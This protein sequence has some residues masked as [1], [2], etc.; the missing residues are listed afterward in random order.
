MRILW[1]PH[2]GWHVPQ[3]A[4]IFCRALS[5]RHEVHVTD[6]VADFYTWRDYL[7]LRYPRNFL[8]RR[9]REGNIIVHGIPRFSPALYVPF[10]RRMNAAVFAFIVR[11]IIQHYRVD[12]VVGTF[13]V[14]P[15]RAPR[16]VFDLFDDNVS[17]WLEY[18]P[19]K[20]YA[21]EIADTERAYLQSADAVVAASSVLAE[22]ARAVTD[23][24][25]HHIPNPVNL[26]SFTHA[27]SRTLREQWGVKGLV[28]GM[29]G[30]YDKTAE[31]NRVLDAAHILSA[32]PLTFV[33]AGRG[34]AIP[35]AKKDVARRGLRRVRF[36]DSVRLPKSAEII[37]AFDI[38]LCPYPKNPGSEACTPMRMLLY[39]AAGIPAVCTDLKEV[40]RMAFPNVVLV[41]DNPESLARGILQAR[42][43][44]RERPDQIA[45][46]DLAHLVEE[47]ERV[48]SG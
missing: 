20:S 7:H 44:P 5:E 45:R 31:L 1:I 2:V 8:Y 38:G 18:G 19:V 24:P 10:L 13:V 25:V 26:E 14:P 16:L 9:S 36:L 12:V 43:L 46:Y 35:S 23:R 15:P 4:K 39:A 28:V 48:L 21:R 11:R 40:R 30:N 37:S 41:E 32:E 3:R 29:L 33:I 17:Y 47:Y 27:D 34:P 6:Y 22:K 42:N